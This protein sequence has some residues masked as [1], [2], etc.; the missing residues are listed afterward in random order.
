MS[1]E[2]HRTDEPPVVWTRGSGCREL[3]EV[4]SD[5]AAIRVDSD[6][7]ATCI[8]TGAALLV[9]RRLSSFDLC[10]VAVPS[11]FSAD[12]TTGVVAT[13][14]T[15][16][17]SSLAAAVAE[18]IGRSLGVSASAVYAHG[19]AGPTPAAARIVQ[20]LDDRFP[21]LR[22]EAVGAA[23]PE[24]M[25]QALPAGTLLV[26][27]APGGSWFQRQF[28][29]PGARIKHKASGGTIV[30]KAAPARVYQ[31]MEPPTAFG[32]H[33]RVAD[34]L[35]IGAGDVVVASES[36]LL[37]VVPGA[38][39][40]AADPDAELGLLAREAAFLAP[41]E[42]IDYARDLVDDTGSTM[43]PVVDGSGNLVGVYRAEK[44]DPSGL[45]QS[46]GVAE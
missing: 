24:A 3:A 4:I 11:G 5:D 17:H 9:S 19:S 46:G 38:T 36:S 25:V 6:P 20:E 42:T 29:G 16:P 39:L 8:R 33:M 15:G 18:K 13:V 10:S 21:D 28:F 7:V 14:G 1:I 23:S 12:E 31:A 32:P 34:A 40:D 43:I 44:A 30:V 41:E 22:I 27:G 35:V 26:V 2:W 37:G 45:W